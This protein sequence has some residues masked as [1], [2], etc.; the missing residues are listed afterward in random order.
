MI[1]D[2]AHNVGTA[3]VEG[4]YLSSTVF[5]ILNYGLIVTG[6]SAAKRMSFHAMASDLCAISSSFSCAHHLSSL[7][8]IVEM[9]PVVDYI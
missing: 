7:F 9:L 2:E 1:S 3:A 5:A 4:S 8:A 6:S